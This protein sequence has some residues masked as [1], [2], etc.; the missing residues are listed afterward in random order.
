MLVGLL[1]VTGGFEAGM[2]FAV[3]VSDLL[4]LRTP[5][6]ND[7][8]SRRITQET[9]SPCSSSAYSAQPSS[10]SHSCTSP[11][12]HRCMLHDSCSPPP[13]PR[14]PQ[15]YEIYRRREVVGISLLFMFIDMMGGVFST[16]SLVFKTE[17]DVI[18]G[19]TYSLVVVRA[20]SLVRA[21]CAVLKVSVCRCWMGWCSCLR[22][23]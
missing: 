12:A 18:A 15:Y 16:L 14:S 1:A 17:F 4:R 9:T 8:T 23:Y 19:V 2:V 10:R 11:P 7:T 20:F 3:R 13:P 5:E 22:L 21:W 6:S